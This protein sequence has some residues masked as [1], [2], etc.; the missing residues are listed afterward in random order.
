[1]PSASG[2][3]SDEPEGA[4]EA[5]ALADADG[6]AVVP[7]VSGFPQAASIETSMR[8]ASRMESI[9]FILILLIFY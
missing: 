3:G 4:A 2:V 5:E 7:D 6:V 8:Q 1:M 9:L